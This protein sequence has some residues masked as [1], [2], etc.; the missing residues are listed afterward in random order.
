MSILSMGI[1]LTNLPSPSAAVISAAT[2]SSAARPAV[3]PATSAMGIRVLGGKADFVS[4]PA[5]NGSVGTS[6][7]L[8]LAICLPLF[9]HVHVGEFVAPPGADQKPFHRRPGLVEGR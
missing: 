3:S 8:R 7:R 9:R 4:I 2:S 1:F 6:M 5:Q